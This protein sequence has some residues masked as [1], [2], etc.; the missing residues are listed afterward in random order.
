LPLSGVTENGQF[1]VN[2]WWTKELRAGEYTV[3]RYDILDTFLKDK[4]IA[5]PYELKIF[6][7][8]EKIFSKSNVS[9]DAKPS[10]SRPSNKNDFEWNIPSDISGIVIVKFENMNGG[11]VANIEFPIVVNKEESTIKYQIP[12]W[13]KNTAGWW[14]TNQIPDSAFVDGI[15]FLVNEKIIIVSDIQKDPLTPYQGIP[16]WLKTNAG[17]WANGEIDDKTFATGIE[18]LIRI[19]LIVV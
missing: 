4:P 3:V 11:K 12:D 1:K 19:G 5:V 13:V 2:L 9:S 8:G 15:E 14:A 7:N 16:E 10:E 18:F 6:H 17:W